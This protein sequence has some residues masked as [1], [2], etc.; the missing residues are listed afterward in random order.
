[1]GNMTINFAGEYC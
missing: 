1:M